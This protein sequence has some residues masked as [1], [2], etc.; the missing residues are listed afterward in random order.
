MDRLRFYD[1]DSDYIQYLKS[2]DHQVPEINY[3]R[4]NKFFCGV[5]LQIDQFHYFAPATSLKKQQRTNFVI[6]DK[7]RPISSIRF[8]FMVPAFSEVLS[9]TNFRLHPQNYQDLVN[10]EIKYCNQNRDKIYKKAKEVYKIGTNK[11]HPLSYTCCDFKLLEEKSS[12]YSSQIA[13]AK[14][15][16]EAKDENEPFK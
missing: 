9:L 5:V 12:V 15:E 13:Q 7:G 11:K 14:R 4:Y 16:T 8:S 10:A 6:H 3:G 2:F 1:I